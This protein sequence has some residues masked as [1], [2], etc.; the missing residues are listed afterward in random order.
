[1]L[2]ARGHEGIIE[3][4]IFICCSRVSLH[5]LLLPAIL[6]VCNYTRLAA[7]IWWWIDSLAADDSGDHR[8][9]IFLK[10]CSTLYI[11]LFITT[12]IH[13]YMLLSR[14]FELAILKCALAGI[15]YFHA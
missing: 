7:G 3:S 6:R 15:G 9:H 4:A 8:F 1:V 11:L 13:Y 5:K 10:F 12:L 14:V 2:A